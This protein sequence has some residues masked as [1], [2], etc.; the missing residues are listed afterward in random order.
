MLLQVY[1]LNIQL[2]MIILEISV[3]GVIILPLLGLMTDK[4]A[5]LWV[6]GLK[7]VVLETR[8]ITCVSVTADI[9]AG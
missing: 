3:I 7:P 9:R 2:Y 5:G 6:L 1:K 8:D 4:I